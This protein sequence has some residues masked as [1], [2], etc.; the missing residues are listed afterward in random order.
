MNISGYLLS[1][2]YWEETAPMVLVAGGGGEQV[3][4]GLATTLFVPHPYLAR[5][6]VTD[7]R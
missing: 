1:V 2:C 6:H 5:S 7:L 4:K 3:E